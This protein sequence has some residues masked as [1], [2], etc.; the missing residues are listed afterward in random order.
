MVGICSATA[1]GDAPNFDG[2]YPLIIHTDA[3]APTA[4]C[5]S[6]PSGM[7][8]IVTNG[9]GAFRGMKAPVAQDGSFD[10]KDG[11]IG[12]YSI[13]RHYWGVIKDGNVSGKWA[14]QGRYVLCTGTFEGHLT[15]S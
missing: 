2:T 11:G 4:A 10:M 14:N 7:A 6:T 8:L 9:E 13:A 3:G 12:P 15:K 5:F 1:W